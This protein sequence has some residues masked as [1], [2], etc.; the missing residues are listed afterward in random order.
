MGYLQDQ[1]IYP[2]KIKQKLKDIDRC[3]IF[4]YIYH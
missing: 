2:P 3:P 4:P 1:L